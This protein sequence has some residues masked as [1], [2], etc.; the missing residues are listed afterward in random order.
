MWLT[1]SE[2]KAQILF[3]QEHH[4]AGTEHVDEHSLAGALQTQVDKAGYTGWFGQALPTGHG[5]TS[6]GVGFLWAKHTSVTVPTE[7]LTGRLASMSCTTAF[8]SILLIN[9]YGQTGASLSKSAAILHKAFTHAGTTGKPT[10][11][12]GDF[13]QPPHEVHAVLDTFTPLTTYVS[14]PTTLAKPP[15]GRPQPLTSTSSTNPS[16]R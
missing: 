1:S 2:V 8:G 4:M 12:A 14:L 6:G 11:I 10:I 3:M 7:L 16:L 9:I 5:G 13:N 15:L